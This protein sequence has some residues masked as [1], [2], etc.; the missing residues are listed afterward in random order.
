MKLFY[1]FSG[2]MGRD[3]EKGGSRLDYAWEKE[4]RESK[5]EGLD[6]MSTCLFSCVYVH[7]HEKKSRVGFSFPAY[8]ARKG[9]RGA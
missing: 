4:R 5:R 3:R 2:W 6:W 8:V 1:P 7:M 9:K